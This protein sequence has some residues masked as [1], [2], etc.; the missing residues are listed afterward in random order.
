MEKNKQLAKRPI[1][2]AI[3]K[4]NGKQNKFILSNKSSLVEE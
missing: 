4:E 3:I 2:K 1:D